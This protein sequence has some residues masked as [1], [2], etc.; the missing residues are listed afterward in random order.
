MARGAYRALKNLQVAQCSRYV[1]CGVIGQEVWR[2]GCVLAHMILGCARLLEVQEPYG[3]AQKHAD[4]QARLGRGTYATEGHG[5]RREG[6]SASHAGKTEDNSAHGE[7]I[8][9][10][11]GSGFF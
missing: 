3:G 9:M 5:G 11:V 2:R 6:N 10:K 1:E 7:R 8:G 4:I